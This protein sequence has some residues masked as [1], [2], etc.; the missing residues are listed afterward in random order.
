MLANGFAE[1]ALDSP[2]LVDE[3]AAP[4]VEKVAIAAAVGHLRAGRSVIVHTGRGPNDAR[5]PQVRSALK[6]NGLDDLAAATQSSQIFGASLGRILRAVLEAVEVHR[7]VVAGGDT[8]GAVARTVGI[9][10]MGMIAE[11]TSGSP[12]CRAVAPASPADGLEITFK[13]GQI[14]KIDFLGLVKNG[15]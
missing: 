7:A 9:E 8:A 3:S 2:R 5:I 14:G 6:A 13:G 11:L 1:V 15:R 12:L 4:S 10:S